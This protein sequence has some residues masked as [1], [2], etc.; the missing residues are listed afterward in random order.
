M[1]RQRF[2]TAPEFR[3]ADDSVVI[4][5]VAGS[6]APLLELKDH[7]GSTLMTVSSS[8]EMQ[9]VSPS[10]TG[11]PT[12]PTAAT[13]TNT[14]QIATT[15]FV[16]GEIS[17]LIDAAPSTL[18][19]LNELAAALGDDANFSSTI[20][21]SLATKAPLAS[22]TFT[23]TVGLPSDTSI[24]NVSST[25]LGYLDG[26]TSGIQTQI[27]TKAPLASPTF[28]GTVTAGDYYSVGNLTL[29]RA[30]ATAWN[31]GASIKLQVDGATY[32]TLG[33]NATHSALQLSG[34]VSIPTSTGYA[35]GDHAFNNYWRPV[36]V[37]GNSYFD[38]NSGSFYV[39][40]ANYYLRD[41]SSNMIQEMNASTITLHKNVSI[42]R[43]QGAIDRAWDNY[44]SITIYNSTG[45]GPQGEFR[46]HGYP[47]GSGGDYSIN[48]RIDGSY[49][50][51]SDARIKTNVTPIT[52]ALDL[53]GNLN[54][55]R[56]QKMNRSLQPETHTN[57]NNGIKFGLIAQD[58][59]EFIPECVAQTPN[60][61]PLEN[62]WCD[63]YA[64]DY[65][66]L[67][68]LLI[69]AIKELTARVQQLEA[70]A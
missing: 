61:M 60:A 41:A 65:A 25:E 58:S 64:M 50:N 17:A 2:D 43:W 53:V 42:V 68:P 18:D 40:S 70:A 49:L 11:I 48:V 24:G 26:V 29:N 63:E 5:Q 27:N 32:L 51:L 55:V 35:F 4:Q 31:T 54:G 57:I 62:G 15:A 47:G 23:G 52:G 36:D 7:T 69:E 38:I 45:L 8:G 21:N 28:T 20:T 34:S 16:R 67:T 3:V 59:I 19:T 14:T 13:G 66:Q 46:I 30:S 33:V 37:Y 1:A 9:S 12:A 44:P 39:D 6:S 22:P 10:L 56:Y